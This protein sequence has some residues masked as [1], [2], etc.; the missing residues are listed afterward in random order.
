M[1]PR[2]VIVHRATELTGLLHDHGT[3]GKAAFFL[4]TRG[5]DLGLVEHRHELQA[6]AM[7]YVTKALPRRWRRASV[8]RS[9]LDRFLFEPGD[10]VVAVGQDGLVANTAKYLDG[11]PVVGINPDPSVNAGVLVPHEPR[12]AREVLAAAAANEAPIQ[13]R[14]MAEAR[15]DDGVRLVALN[16]LFVGH[17][18]HQSARYDLAHGGSSVFQSSSGLIVATGTGCTGWAASVHRCHRS[19]LAMPAPTDPRLIFFVREAWP[20]PGCDTDVVEGHVRPD[21]TLR[22]TCRMPEGGV[23]FG[24]GIEGDSIPLRWGQTIEITRAAR[25]LRLVA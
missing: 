9:D 19:G 2:A 15:S 14:T 5:R 20:G 10:L 4:E 11:Q 17:R 8:E 22:I 24:D 6:R 7:G 25:Q 21:R 3:K 18:T 16:E 12:M 1:E 13:A 23:V